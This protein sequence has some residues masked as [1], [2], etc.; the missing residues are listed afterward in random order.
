MT[1]LVVR[2][3]EDAAATVARLTAR[4]I[5]ALAAPASAIEPLAA[6]IGEG[7]RGLVV[8]SANA[9]RAVAGRRALHALPVYAVGDRTAEAARA[10]GFASVASAAGTAADLVR[11][12][13]DRLDPAG[14]PLA[15]LS[16]RHTAA[17]LAGDLRRAGFEV[18]RIIVYEA[19]VARALPA[20][21]VA[22]LESH[23]VRAV[24]LYSPRGARLFGA[25]VA[26]SGLRGR[27]SG[28]LAVCLSPQIAD[29]AESAGFGHVAAAPSPD[30]AALIALLEQRL[31]GG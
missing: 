15:Y 3:A 6:D 25:L 5:A 12:I 1:V 8:T 20:A 18:D 24:L 29:A 28:L 13:V 16:A 23:E 9:V 19:V 30:E 21:A 22:A 31:A 11:M 17:D 27:L 10:A 2:P 14:G 7:Y 26:R 4:G